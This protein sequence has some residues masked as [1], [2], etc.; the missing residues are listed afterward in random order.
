MKHSLAKTF[1]K[2]DK[3]YVLFGVLIMI[4]LIKA[5]NWEKSVEVRVLEVL[6]GDTVIVE[7]SNKKER[8]RLKNIDA[9][10]LG[11]MA[12]GDK[13]CVDIGEYSKQYLKSRLEQKLIKLDWKIRDRYKRILGEI[14][15]KRKNINLE[16]VEEGLAVIYWFNTFDSKSKAITYNEAIKFAKDNLIGIWGIG[17]FYD[18]YKHR[19]KKLKSESYRCTHVMNTFSKR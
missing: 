16:L 12:I 15:L 1:L 7:I 19:S 4:V 6:D 8:I 2:A 11:Q 17:D 13:G 9:P 10:E 18:P 3:N 5:I 14:T